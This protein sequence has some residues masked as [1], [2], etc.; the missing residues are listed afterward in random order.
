MALTKVLLQTTNAGVAEVRSDCVEIP[1]T[2]PL[3]VLIDQVVD[4]NRRGNLEPFQAA[5]APFGLS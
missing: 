4:V 2:Y 5:E 3:Q 1:A